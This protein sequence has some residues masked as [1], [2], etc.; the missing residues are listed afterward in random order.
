[1]VDWTDTE[2]LAVLVFDIVA[3]V[4]AGW[5]ISGRFTAKL[6]EV[7]DRKSRVPTDSEE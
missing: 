7:E 2:F 1:M 6:R 5:W 4:I 3:I